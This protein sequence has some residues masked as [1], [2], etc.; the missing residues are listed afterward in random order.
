MRTRE[1]GV[2]AVVAGLLA[3]SSAIA[4]A[5]SPTS[6][7][8]YMTSPAPCSASN[9]LLV[10]SS[11]DGAGCAEAPDVAI[12]VPT[13]GKG[14]GTRVPD[15]DY[16]TQT[17]PRIT[18]SKHSRLTGFIGIESLSPTTA[19][20]QAMPGYVAADYAI[21]VNGVNVGSGHVE[22][23]SLPSAP[24]TGLFT[25][26]LPSSLA[27]Q[28]LRNVDVT[29]KYVGCMGIPA[30]VVSQDGANHSRLTISS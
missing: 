3:A 12:L 1:C 20:P 30:C 18:L 13:T 6:A 8:F 21:V 10:Q 4:N 14:A 9:R 17:V 26:T 25:F 28:R 7:T 5:G 19:G 29:V 11:A 23:P 24:A 16:E 2:L 27:H 22:G 15:E